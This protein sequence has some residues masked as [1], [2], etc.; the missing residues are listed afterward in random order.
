MR[1]YLI[2]G[3][4]GFLGSA[5]T[6]RLV[7]AG[8]AVRVLDNN[9]R[10]TPRRLARC[11]GE[12]ETIE[13]DVRDAEAVTRA[14]QGVDCIVH[15]AAINGTEFFYTK[16]E[17]V[18]DVAIRGMLAVVD[19]CRANHVGDLVVASSS[20]VYQTPPIVPTPE[21]VPLVVPD[22]LN[23]R[24]SYG[25]GKL[26]SELMAVNYGRSGFERVVIFRPHNVYGSDMGSEHVIPQFALRAATATQGRKGRTIDFTIQGDGL[27]T[28]AF[29]HVEDFTDGLMRVI[30]HGRHLTV[31][32]IGSD[33]EVTIGDLARQI[34]AMF[35]CTAMLRPNAAPLG[36]TER[37]CPDLSR[38]R[39]LGY[40]PLIALAQGLPGVVSWYAE[41][42]KLPPAA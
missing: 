23:P 11:A 16:P 39:A 29:V 40:A 8:H 4:T 36:A 20:E 12:I 37:R 3:G 31:Y 10:G 14:A 38:L 22:V 21:T 17:A 28:R 13:A 9:S 24:Y 26:T 1:R 41:H 2:T 27:Q 7:A 6:Q 35:G 33:E 18:L 32:H 5:L 15:M 19:A 42:A 30:E 34:V 25:G